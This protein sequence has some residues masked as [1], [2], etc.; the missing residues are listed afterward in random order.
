MN[1]LTKELQGSSGT[2]REDSE[3]QQLEKHIVDYY[4]TKRKALADELR[5]IEKV[6]LEHGVI[7]RPLCL[8]ARPR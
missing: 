8:Q 7:S 4:M 6:L 5:Y 1:V 3:P 2:T